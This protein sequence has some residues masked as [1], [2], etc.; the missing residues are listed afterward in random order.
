MNETVITK[1]PL[2]AASNLFNQTATFNNPRITD[3]FTFEKSIGTACTVRKGTTVQNCIFRENVSTWGGGGVQMYQG[4]TVIFIIIYLGR[5]IEMGGP[6]CIRMHLLSILQ[7]LWRIVFLIATTDVLTII[8][9][10]GVV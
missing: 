4:G 6:D 7:C 9:Y 10:R 1:D 5:M 3:G 2:L 8:L